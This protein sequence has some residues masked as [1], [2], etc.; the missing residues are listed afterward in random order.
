MSNRAQDASPEVIYS[1]SHIEA[2]RV[3]RWEYVR[4]RN[5]TGVVI[6]VAV[7][8]AGELILVEQPRVP[9]GTTVIELPA[10]LAGDIS[11]AED[12]ALETAAL[13][14]LEEE[15]GWHAKAITRLVAGP[16]SAGL[17]SEVVTFF[18]ADGLTRIG[19]GGGDATEDITVHHVPL[20][21]VPAFIAQ[22]VAAGAM[23][24]PKV[25]AGL[26]FATR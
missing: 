19:E 8:P 6:I 23:V 4:R 21:E 24:D 16:V 20:A 1:G 5:S 26:Y 14:E 22:R 25:F 7:T 13:R 15:T 2:V 11:G 17:T 3:G 9:V 12:E 10:G 18:R